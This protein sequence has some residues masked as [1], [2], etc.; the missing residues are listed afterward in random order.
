MR[1]YVWNRI[2]G[3]EQDLC[4]FSDK[5]VSTLR[6]VTYIL[7]GFHSYPDHKPNHK[8]INVNSDIP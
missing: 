6:Q 3:Y 4:F 7:I 2:G 8:P 1:E 5:W